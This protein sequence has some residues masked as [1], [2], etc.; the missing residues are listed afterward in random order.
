MPFAAAGAD[1]SWADVVYVLVDKYPIPGFCLLILAALSWGGV[2]LM[3]SLYDRNDKTWQARV[4]D[5][6][7]EVNALRA[8]LRNSKPKKG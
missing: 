8:Y 6:Q 4:K 1:R 2:K 7:D 3:R 5:L